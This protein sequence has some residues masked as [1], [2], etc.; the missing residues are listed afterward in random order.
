[1]SL[2]TKLR[3][4]PKRFGVIAAV[5]VAGASVALTFAWGPSRDTYTVAH[6][7]DHITFNSITDNPEVGDER[8]FVVVKDAANTSEGGWQDD[9]TV[10]PGKEYLVRVY[11]HNNAAD[12]LNLTATNTRVMAALGTNTGTKVG[13]T[14]YVSADNATP[15][16]VWDDASFTS[17]NSFNMAYVAGSAKIYNNATGAAGRSVSDSIVDGS[18]ALVGYAAN[19]GKVPGCFQ[20]ASYVTFKVKPQFASTASFDMSKSVRKSGTTTWGETVASKAG[21]TV[22]YRIKY[23]NTSTTQQDNVTVRDKMPAGVSYVPGTTKLFL[24]SD[25]LTPRSMSDNVT[26]GGINIGS[27]SPGG[28]A[29]VIFDAKVNANDKLPTCGP[30]TLKNVASV[31]T[32]YGTKEEGADVTVDKECATAEAKYSCD[33]LAVNQIS[34]TQFSFKA[35]HTVENATYVR[36]V[37]VVRDASGKEISRQNSTDGTLSYTQNTVGKYSVEAQVVVKVD[38]VEKVATDADC[39]KEFEVKNEEVK[40]E[41]ACTQLELIEKSRDSFEFATT[42]KAT[43]N[44][45]IKEVKVDFGDN[46]SAVVDY[47]KN[48]THTYAKP[49]TYTAIASVTFSVDGKTVADVSSDDCKVEVVVEQPPVE[50]CKPGIPM[51]DARCEETPETPKNPETPG[52]LPSTGPAAL[53]GGLFGSSA[54]GLGVHGWLTSRRAFRAAAR[55]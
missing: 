1:M 8:N 48:A 7:A 37:F 20:Y 26:S 25:P 22:Q 47:G 36:T 52:E 39:K 27:Y 3:Y 16:E 9:V 17:S 11:V 13:L 21:D 53:I 23:T 15:G 46:S 28:T 54:L 30:N 51:N 42:A 14:G 35:D 19:D 45:T 55:R 33:A 34:R 6:P 12:S 43:G 4:V 44:V 50:E 5:V 29:L 31:E 2:L 10:Q 18:G 32:D 24:G 40:N 49:G 41:Y 38:G